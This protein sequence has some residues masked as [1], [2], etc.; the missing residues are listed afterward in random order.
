MLEFI[1]HMTITPLNAIG[2]YLLAGVLLF[3][4]M[5]RIRWYAMSLLWV[6]FGTF[7]RGFLIETTM[8]GF[9]F[10]LTEGFFD[11]YFQHEKAKA[12]SRAMKSKK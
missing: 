7:D 3:H 9:T 11:T 1:N 5:K 4:D 10:M 2:Y 12:Q 6:S 8:L